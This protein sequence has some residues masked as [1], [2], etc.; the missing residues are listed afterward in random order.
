MFTVQKTL[1]FPGCN[2]TRFLLVGF[3]AEV[4]DK[5]ELPVFKLLLDFFWPN[6]SF[7]LEA[8]ELF[9]NVFPEIKR[10]G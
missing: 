3:L 7:E 6:F 5:K 1:N 2:T 8:E 4:A 10:L 9:C